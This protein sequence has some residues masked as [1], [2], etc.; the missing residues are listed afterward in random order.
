MSKRKAK[1]QQ[2]K[3]STLTLEAI[4]KSG[5][6][7]PVKL[8]ARIVPIRKGE[9]VGAS[10]GE[11]PVASSVEE[12]A[13]FRA[14]GGRIIEPPYPL[15]RLAA[16]KENNGELGTAIEAMVTN[17]VGFG[18]QLR[19]RRMPEDVR[20]ALEKDIL[21]ER[22]RLNAFLETVHP[23]KSLTALLRRTKDDQHSMGNGYLELIEDR[24]GNLSGLSHV[25]GH[26]IRLGPKEKRPVKVLVPRIRSDNFMIDRIPMWHRFRKYAFVSHNRKV[27]FKEAG[28]PRLLDK[29]TGKFYV[30]PDKVPFNK[31]A[32]S[33]IHYLNYSSISPYGVPLWIGNVF[34]VYGARAA[35]EINFLT[36]CNNNIPSMFVIVEGGV[37]TDDSIDRLTEF[38]EAQMAGSSNYSKF[39]VLEGE[40]SDEGSVNPASFRIKVTPLKGL[41][42]KDELWQSYIGNA[43]DKT[44]QSFRLP[45]IFVGRSDDYT[46]ATAD[47]SR[48]IADEQ[49]FAPERSEDGH[50]LN[51][52]VLLAKGVEARYHTFRFNHPNITDDIELIRLMA[53][54]ERSGA[55]TPRRA[56]RLVLDVFGEDLGP[57]PKGIDLDKPYSLTFAEAQ[58]GGA[59]VGQGSAPGGEVA[60]RVIDGLLD[61]RRNIEKELDGRFF[62]E[63]N[64]NG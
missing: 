56:D 54:A 48:D 37:L 58:K 44:R 14:F 47:T 20:K 28:D 49:I 59:A 32:T 33:L 22:L 2:P 61:L 4:D 15:R 62:L 23:T 25:H 27:W 9:G 50:T 24:N 7:F 46:R 39:I 3:R 10:G 45:P 12:E 8:R 1:P 34:S 19:E 55:M 35:E 38:T 18:W 6:R 64:D 51:R 16:T 42:Q 11:D 5:K 52:N 57:L 60:R 36:L 40:V 13:D 43:R 29:E 17:T 31:R 30:D 53:I 41:Q 26:S 21:E 63:D